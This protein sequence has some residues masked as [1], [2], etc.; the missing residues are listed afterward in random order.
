MSEGITMS[1]KLFQFGE[2]LP[3]YDI[4]VFNE[5]AVR[6]AAGIL[7]AFAIVSFMNAILLGNFQ[8]TKI[9][10]AAFLI[11]FTLRLF[12]N[13][14]FAPSLI[15]GQWVVRNQTPEYTGAPQKRFAWGIGFVLALAMFFLIVVN[16]LVGPINGLICLSCLIFMFFE[17][18]FGICI[19]CKIYN[20]FNK[21]QA[22]LC[23]GN[24]CD[25]EVAK[26]NQV[27]SSQV[28]ALIGAVLVFGLVITQSTLFNGEVRMMQIPSMHDTGR[29]T[30]Q[31]AVDDA[32]AGECQVPDWAISM[33]HE[34]MW[35][36]HNDCQ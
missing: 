1:N 13:P 7:F 34:E 26:G 30:I 33:G 2:I 25:L 10:V 14:K 35:K 29:L 24:S 27:K 3:E 31:G 20:V 16:N 36:E 21:E 6:A 8:P 28:V 12:V 5:R 19:G 9:F 32:G 15:I 23:P 22:K 4:P 18:A 11:D 17:S